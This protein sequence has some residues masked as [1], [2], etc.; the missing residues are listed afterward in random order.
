MDALEMASIGRCEGQANW[1]RM[2][3]QIMPEL[4]ALVEPIAGQASTSKR[5]KHFYTEA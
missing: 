3:P 4:D 5:S 1:S 2:F